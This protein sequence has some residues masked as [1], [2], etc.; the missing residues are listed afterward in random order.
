MAAAVP[1]EL[2][3]YSTIYKLY[4]GGVPWESLFESTIA[5]CENGIKI[6]RH[7]F[8]SLRARETT[9][10]QDDPILRYNKKLTY[11]LSFVIIF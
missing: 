1:G 8:V 2:R 4:G 7:L 5:L 9:L 11:I 6:N 10:I 3:G